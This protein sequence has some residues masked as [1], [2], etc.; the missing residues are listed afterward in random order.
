M[1]CPH[2]RFALRTI[3][4]ALFSTFMAL[5]ALAADASLKET[6]VTATRNEAEID[7]LSATVTRVGR[8]ELD[9]R[10]PVDEAE[11]PE[12]FFQARQ[13]DVGED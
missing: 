11:G 3:P 13:R 10:L 6:V 7:K 1:L 2:P 4:L 8:K 9:R 5:P 12:E